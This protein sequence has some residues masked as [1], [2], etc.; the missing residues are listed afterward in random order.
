MSNKVERITLAITVA[1]FILISILDLLNFL[2]A[3]PWLQERLPSLTLLAVALVAS[4]LVAERFGKLERIESAL[5][6]GFEETVRALGGVSVMRL[7]EPE[8]GLSYLAKKATGAKIRL[9]LASMSPAIPRNNPGATAWENALDEVVN[10]NLVRFRYIGVFND[11]TRFK[12]IQKYLSNYKATKFFAGYFPTHD[13]PIPLS[14]FLIVDQNEVIVIFPHIYDEPETW[15]SIKQ[16]EI[17]ETFVKYY[18]RLWEDC[19]KITRENLATA[20]LVINPPDSSVIPV[21]TDKTKGY[22]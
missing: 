20:V 2:D 10:A 8:M 18:Q 1:I 17:V 12:R 16:P 9:D 6:S 15:L 21:D 11:E 14:N 19:T 7:A 13:N 22:A 4:Y 5:N 3:L